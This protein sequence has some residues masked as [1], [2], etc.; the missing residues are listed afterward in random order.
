MRAGGWLQRPELIAYDNFVQRLANREIASDPRIVICGMT[1]E[2]LVKYGH[3]LDDAR[4]ATLLELIVTEKPCVVGLDMYRDLKEPR[5]GEFYPKLAETLLRLEQVIA[6]ERIPSVKPPPA[7]AD[8]PDRVVPNNLPTDYQI[9]GIYRRAPLF[10]EG[11]LAEPRECFALALARTYLEAHGVEAK[12]VDAPGGGGGGPLLQLGKTTFPRLTPNA[13][14]YFGLKIRDYEIL[15]DFRGPQDFRTFSFGD[16]LE[17]R[18]PAGALKDAIVIVGIMAPSV[19]DFNSTPINAELRGPIHH[20][21]I[22]NQFLRSALNGASPTRWWPEPAQ[23]AWIGF[24]T[25]LGGGLGLALRS[26]WRLA[27]AL[28]LLLGALVFAGW[29]ALLHGLWIPVTTPAIGAIAAATFVTSFVVFLERS[30]RRAM[31]AL[32]SRHVSTKVA[33]AL[34]AERDQFLD[35]GRLKPQRLTATVLFTDLKGFATISEDM[36]PATLMNWINEY[37]AAIARHVDSHG[38]MINAFMGDAI[39]AVFGAPAARA[40]E[41][42]I[43]HDAIRAVECA[44]A[45]RRELKELNAGWAAR[46]MPTV[47]MRVGIFTGPLACG[48]IGT[49][50]R[51]E[52]TVLGDTANTAARLESAGKDVQADES[53]A[54]CTILI[55]DATYQ[56]L[57]DRFTTKEVGSLKLK[58]KAK[59][60]IVHSVLCAATNIPPI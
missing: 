5:S 11:R 17:K 31:S 50:E 38:G 3:P 33:D 6:I 32:F 18:V 27:P 59:E 8:K 4:F 43:D 53:T 20:A 54:N 39:M 23:D 14:G 48:S 40:R 21:M 22:V 49:A 44:L 56:R 9:D 29:V 47:G 15:S 26:P 57:R 52:F 36:D 10:L 12:M 58:G 42:D 35:G 46:R 25:L 34:W 45:M 2:D 37:M 60:V 16:V 30:E 1:Q 24:A 51:L 13:G 7:L 28:A 55:G 19:K 41:E